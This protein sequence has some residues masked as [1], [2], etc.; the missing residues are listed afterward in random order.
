VVDSEL[1]RFFIAQYHGIKADTVVFVPMIKI[2][3]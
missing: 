3:K 1:A 2:D